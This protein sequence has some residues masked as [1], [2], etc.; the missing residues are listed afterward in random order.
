M[1]LDLELRITE[2]LRTLPAVKLQWLAEDIA[3]V[4]DRVRYRDLVGQGRNAEGQTTKGWP[5]AYVVSVDGTL[6]GVEATRDRRNWT[7]HLKED[8]ANAQSPDHPNLNGYFFVAGYPDHIPSPELIGE[9]RRRVCELGIAEDRVSI[10]I[11]QALVT[12]LL[13]P[14]YART[15]QSILDIS[16]RPEHFEMIQQEWI[17]ND[18]GR[19]FEPE[20]SEYRGKLVHRPALADSV[21]RLLEMEGYAVVRGQGA[22]GKTVLAYLIAAG[23]NYRVLPSYYLNFAGWAGQIELLRGKIENILVEFGGPGVLFVLDN[24]HL[25]EM[26]AV[27][28]FRSWRMLAQSRGTR[29]LLLG[30]EVRRRGRSIDGD[31]NNSLILRA[32]VSEVRGVYSRLAQRD[33]TPGQAIPEP[34]GE[35]LRLWVKTFGGETNRVDHSTDLMAF[36]AAAR[37][38]MRFLLRGDWELDATHAREEVGKEYL[39]ALDEGERH[40]LLRLASLP[41]DC[42][43]VLD[44]LAAPYDRFDVCIGKGLV[45]ETEHGEDRYVRYSLAHASLGRLLL[46]AAHPSPDRK[47]EC[48]AVARLSTFSGFVIAKR[49]LD[50]GDGDLARAV[51]VATTENPDWLKTVNLHHMAFNLKAAKLLGVELLPATEPVPAAIC[52]Q[53]CDAVLRTPLHVVVVF[54]TYLSSEGSGLSGLHDGL[55]EQLIRRSKEFVDRSRKTVLGELITFLTYAN[56]ESSGLFG[57]REALVADLLRSREA[58]CEHARKADLHFLVRFLTYAS[59]KQNGLLELHR[60]TVANL[61]RN[62]GEFSEHARE[63]EFNV[64]MSFLIYSS[65]RSNGLWEVRRATVDALLQHV[66]K[67]CDRARGASLSD[68]AAFLIYAR[69]E[70]N[71]LSALHKALVADIERNTKEIAEHMCRA[72]L[73]QVVKFLDDARH[74]TSGFTSDFAKNVCNAIDIDHWNYLRDREKPRQPSS[75]LN[76]QKLFRG[77]G[78]PELVK[79]VAQ[80][81]LTAADPKAWRSPVGIHHLSAMLGILPEAERD[82][83]ALFLNRVVAPAWLDENY[84]QASSGGLAISW[85]ALATSLPPDLHAKFVVPSIESRLRRELALMK[86]DYIDAWATLFCTI[87]SAAL[88][89]PLPAFRDVRWP[90]GAALEQIFANPRYAGSPFGWVQ[91]QFWCGLRELAR[92]SADVVKVPV[93]EGREALAQ[94]KILAPRAPFAV[95]LNA[96]MIAWLERCDARGWILDRSENPIRLDILGRISEPARLSTGN[97]PA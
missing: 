8:I 38:R 35:T 52:E 58:F 37:N 51:F 12:E 75:I 33:A 39:S 20:A 21:E 5:D 63:A 57:L 87:G 79:V 6:D 88:L 44:A 59:E 85:F 10:L 7:Q 53:L 26:F 17:S 42:F 23:V 76:V 49:A 92:Q 78:R 84:S 29:L 96:A 81:L 36:S 9:W 62:K 43:L 46:A 89:A 74:E 41:D 28:V 2:K 86:P 70:R 13:M 73:D 77:L 11:G 31:L 82:S 32:G 27:S 65:E 30:R 16:P 14:Q 95:A 67:L 25:E 71:G 55:K 3:L 56:S 4:R 94:W 18:V 45:F 68:L 48:C 80:K 72:P 22:A 19:P 93:R 61:V 24:I 90:A 15:L 34:P 50:E 69:A 54:L 97:D 66:D 47:Q 1:R 60:L 64:L 91:L 40:N 83:L